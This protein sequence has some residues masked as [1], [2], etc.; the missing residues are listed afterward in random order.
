MPHGG[1]MGDADFVAAGNGCSDIEGVAHTDHELGKVK[2]L[3]PEREEQRRARVFPPPRIVASITLLEGRASLC[4]KG[5]D[6]RTVLPAAWQ[7]R[8]R[9]PRPPEFNQD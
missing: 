7:G 9:V 6:L 1:S 8:R 3:S 2:K 5:F 4:A